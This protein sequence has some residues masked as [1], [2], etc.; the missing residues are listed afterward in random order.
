MKFFCRLVKIYF[1]LSKE[2]ITKNCH[3]EIMQLLGR[4]HSM[5]SPGIRFGSSFIQ[6][7]VEDSFFLPNTCNIANCADNNTLYATGN[8]FEVI[9]QKLSADIISLQSWFDKNY[10]TLLHK[11][12]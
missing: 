5:C 7:F 8:C 3:R 9:I 11:F 1:K 12:T 10:I 2:Q 4:N 6:L